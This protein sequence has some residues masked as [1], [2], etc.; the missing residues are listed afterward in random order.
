MRRRTVED[1]RRARDRRSRNDD[2]EALHGEF[3][4]R[5]RPD[6]D[7]MPAGIRRALCAGGR[8]DVVEREPPRQHLHREPDWD[9]VGGSVAAVVAN[10]D[11]D[12]N[13]D[14]AAVIVIVIA[15]AIVIAVAVAIAIAI[16]IA[17][18]IIVIAAIA[19][20]CVRLE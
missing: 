3:A 12:A 8:R 20:A 13:T 15:F 19:S 17:I 4:V 7:R 6:D 2:R 1:R 18:V 16:A 11:A 14:A 10:A 9:V 5:A